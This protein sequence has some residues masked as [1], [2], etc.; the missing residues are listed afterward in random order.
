MGNSCET[1]FV[2]LQ[3]P[4]LFQLQLKQLSLDVSRKQATVTRHSA[5]TS[6]ALTCSEELSSVLMVLGS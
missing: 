3:E 4:Q 2:W 5:G 6:L 1:R